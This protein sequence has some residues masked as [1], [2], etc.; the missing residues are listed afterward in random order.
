MYGQ[1]ITGN[2]NG[3]SALHI[4]FTAFFF[5]IIKKLKTDLYVPLLTQYAE[6]FSLFPLEDLRAMAFHD[7]EIQINSGS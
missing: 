1:R 2:G 6:K 4:F 3:S 7:Q 5:G